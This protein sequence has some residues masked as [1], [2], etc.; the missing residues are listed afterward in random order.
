MEW[1]HKESRRP[2]S[3]FIQRCLLWGG[4]TLWGLIPAY[5]LGPGIIFVCL[6][7]HTEAT[8]PPPKAVYNFYNITIKCMNRE[9][10][11]KPRKR[12]MEQQS[13]RAREAS[14]EEFQYWGADTTKGLSHVFPARTSLSAGTWD[15]A[16]DDE[17]NI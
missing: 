12:R 2:V 11:Y 1:T 5:L 6:L 14:L 9:T 8:V 4:G 7:K 10:K 13:L 15:T 16:P 17:C 3:H